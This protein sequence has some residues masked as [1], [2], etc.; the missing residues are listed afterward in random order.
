MSNISVRF[1]ML[2][3]SNRPA[4]GSTVHDRPDCGKCHGAAGDTGLV[5]PVGVQAPVSCGECASGKHD[6]VY[7][8]G[9]SSRTD[10]QCVCHGLPLGEDKANDSR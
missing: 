2:A 6:S 9:M 3:G 10:C 7:R 4:G 8:Q 1:R 5:V